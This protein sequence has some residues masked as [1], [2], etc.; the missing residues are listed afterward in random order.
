MNPTKQNIRCFMATNRKPTI[1]ICLSYLALSPLTFG[2]E[3]PEFLL[4]FL[5]APCALSYCHCNAKQ[6]QWKVLKPLYIVHLILGLLVQAQLEHN[7]GAT[8][9]LNS[10]VRSF[11][12]R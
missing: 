7:H 5:V 8:T 4:P 10:F 9:F 1:E 6:H 3:D 2:N 11:P 12:H